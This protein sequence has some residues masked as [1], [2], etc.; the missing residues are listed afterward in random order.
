[1]VKRFS[2]TLLA[3]VLFLFSSTLF[4]KTY[5]VGVLVPLTGPHAE[6]GIPLKNAAELF[7]ARFNASRGADGAKLEL[8]VRDDY[9]DPEKARTVAAEM[10]RDNALLA[11]IGHYYPA[12]A[13]ATARVFAD[14]GIP[15]LSPNVSSPAVLGANKWMFSVN[16]PD[17]VQG[18]FMA[19]YI[20]E[21]LKKDNVLLI[22][23][24]DSFG[25]SLKDAFVRKASR[26]GLK[27]QKVVEAGNPAV[28]ADWAAKNLPDPAENGRIGIV[29]ALTHSEPGLIFLPQLRELGI[30]A[31]VMAPNAWSNPKFLTDLDE[32]YTADVYLTSAFLWEIANQKAS[33]FAEAYF[34]KFGKRPSVAAAMTYDAVLLI[35]QAIE[36]LQGPESKSAPT[37]SGIR[38]LLA[39]IDSLGAVEGVTGNLYFNRAQDKT[40]EYVAKYI[41]RLK[42]EHA[43]KALAMKFDSRSGGADKAEGR[44]GAFAQPGRESGGAKTTQ[45]ENR[46]VRRDVFV[47]MMKD[48]R[49]KAAAVQ[50]NQPREEYVLKELYERV[51]QGVVMVVD[52]VPYH[53]VDVVFV[54]VD[55]IRINDVNIKDMLWDVDLFM[56]FKWAGGRLDA[57]DIERITAI[58]AVKEQSVLLKENLS[59]PVKY[60]AYRKRLTLGAP[61]DLSA[62]PFDAQTLPL[63]IAHMNRN[64]THVML[65][66]DSRHMETAPV[67]DIKPQEWTYGGRN[68]FSDLYRYQSTFGDPDYRMG[69]GYKSPVYFSTVNLEIV[70]KRILNPYLYTFFL[71]LAIIL[72]IVLLVLW[73][74]IDQ[75]SPR[76]GAAI[77]GL[78][79]ILVYHM[80]QKNA[81][82]KVGYI[83]TADYYFLVAYAFVVAIIICIIFTQTLMASGQKEMAKRWN[84]WLNIGA[85]VSVTTIYAAMTGIAIYGASAEARDKQAKGQNGDSQYSMFLHH[86]ASSGSLS[87]LPA[88]TGRLKYATLWSYETEPSLRARPPNDACC[89]DTSSQPRNPRIAIA[90]LK[91]L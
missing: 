22:H 89:T 85:M 8:V 56:W 83:M 33:A 2:R 62:F 30:N 24:T 21:V 3:L 9:D 47:S 29:A 16:F 23:N 53:I 64:S 70:I 90:F 5:R 31:P 42:Q 61:F 65:V 12:T 45:A 71:P 57:K 14:A 35:A 18:S 54:G 32:K 39:R 58:N 59:S 91:G 38:D 88:T 43:P 6:K 77:S 67:E 20:K 86:R 40:A 48:G 80:S 7:A 55:V 37:R 84:R 46:A 51:K 44:T 87:D 50:L 63:S 52:E 66:L 1:M 74:P 11:V 28:S 26:I 69:K 72:G 15:F 27:V 41:A 76:L 13:L 34:K 82:P 36:T 19:V 81:F 68:A 60:R 10:V 17:E 25:I 73:V 79:G 75:F 49:F 4:A 78:V